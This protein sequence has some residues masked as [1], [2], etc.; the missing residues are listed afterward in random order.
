VANTTWNP[1]DTTTGVT[2]SGGNLTITIAL[3]ALRNIRSILGITAGKV[4]WEYTINTITGQLQFG[5]ANATAV[6]SNVAATVPSSGN[7]ALVNTSGVPF[8]N[9]VQLSSQSVGAFS[10][11]Q[12]ACF[13]MDFNAQLM[14]VRRTAA[15]NWNN[16]GTANPATGVGG[17][18][19]SIVG[20]GVAG[21]AIAGGN[22]ANPTGS[23]TANFGDS[24]FSGAVP[25]GFAAGFIQGSASAAVVRAMI[26]A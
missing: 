20:A 24:A 10:A 26:L 13:A 5:L 15:G 16:S 23:I 1:S 21:F 9:G 19:V 6:L 7:C 17:I 4:Y 25:S 22:N 18:S 14:W 12:V 2:L 11:G 3:N 8:V